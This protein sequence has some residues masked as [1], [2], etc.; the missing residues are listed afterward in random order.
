[1]NHISCPNA[2]HCLKFDGHFF[3]LP[4]AKCHLPSLVVPK[5]TNLQLFYCFLAVFCLFVFVVA[6]FSHEYLIP[7]LSNLP[8]KHLLIDTFGEIP[9]DTN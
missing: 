5:P 7:S 4:Q 9:R 8:E 3:L 6:L 1:M 2:T